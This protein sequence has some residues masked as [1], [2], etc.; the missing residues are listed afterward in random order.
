[1][2]H[3]GLRTLSRYEVSPQHRVEVWIIAEVGFLK[4][5]FSFLLSA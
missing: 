1:M 3:L 2:I 4:E 5:R